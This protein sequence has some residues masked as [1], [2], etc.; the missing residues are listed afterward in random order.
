MDKLEIKYP[1]IEIKM[2]E[3]HD[4]EKRDKD[5]VDTRAGKNS[6]QQEIVK[7]LNELDDRMTIVADLWKSKSSSPFTAS[8]FM[9]KIEEQIVDG[10]SI[11]VKIVPGRPNTNKGGDG[12]IIIAI[13]PVF[14]NFSKVGDDW[15]FAGT[16]FEK[17]DQAMKEFRP[18]AAAGSDF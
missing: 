6:Q 11:I 18:Q 7:H 1:S 12:S 8:V 3:G 9:G 13:P 4:P 2:G 17:T 14:V 10:D 5:K 15:K 16:N